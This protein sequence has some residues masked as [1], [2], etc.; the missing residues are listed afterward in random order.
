MEPQEESL[1]CV[2]YTQGLRCVHVP[3]ARCGD[4]PCAI[5]GEG[6]ISRPVFIGLPVRGPYW[7][8]YGSVLIMEERIPGACA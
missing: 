2:E 3:G 1:F 4:Q 6:P 5:M 7:Q 8:K